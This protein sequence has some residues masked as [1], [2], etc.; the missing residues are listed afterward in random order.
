MNAQWEKTIFKILCWLFLEVLF[1]LIGID[2]LIDYSE[3]VLMPKVDVRV[4]QVMVR[5]NYVPITT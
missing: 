1:N 2:D 4:N 3:F 5:V